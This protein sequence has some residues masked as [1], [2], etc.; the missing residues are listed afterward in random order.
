MQEVHDQ[1][2]P[3]FVSCQAKTP[4]RAVGRFF[5]H[6]CKAPIFKSSLVLSL[7]RQKA[8]IRGSDR[9]LEAQENRSSVPTDIRAPDTPSPSQIDQ[10]RATVPQASEPEQ[11]ANSMCE[12]CPM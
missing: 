7:F 6:S 3:L 11:G 12:P 9:R 10:A 4:R 5:N 2:F 8:E 1:R